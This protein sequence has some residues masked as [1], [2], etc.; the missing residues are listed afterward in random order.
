MQYKQFKKREEEEN[1]GEQRKKKKSEK[2]K[3]KDNIK[4]SAGRQY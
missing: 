3:P 2:T 4:L 1:T